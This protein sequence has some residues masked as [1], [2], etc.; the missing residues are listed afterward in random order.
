MIR[1]FRYPLMAT[2]AQKAVLVRW[3]ESCRTLFNAALE[4]RRDAWRRCGKSLTYFDQTRDLTVLRS[5]DPEW[6][7][8]PKE[9]GRSPLRNLDRAFQAFFRR[10][11]TGQAPGHPRFKGRGRYDSFSIGRAPVNG[12]RVLIPKLGPVRFRLYRELKGRVLD[13]TLRLWAGRWHVSFSCDLGDAPLKRPVASAIG[14]DVGLSAFATL[15]DGTRVGNPRF[16]KIAEGLLARRQRSLARKS[17]GSRSRERAKRLVQRAHAHVRNQ[18]L[19]FALK[20]ACELFARHDL[21]AYE[22]LDIKG[23]A[24]GT[25]AKSVHDAAWGV[26]ARALALKAE[27]AGAWAVP[28]DPHK[29]SAVCNACGAETPKALGDRI[30]RCP[31]GLVLDRDH[32]AALNILALG[33]SAVEVLGRSPN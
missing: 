29:T 21:V 15:S 18:R 11:K 24:G 33:R 13:V 17:R 25:L 6:A 8:I 7:G 19:D 12:D 27:C 9:V 23:L 30:H 5:A 32:N 31:C 16:F 4:Q 10:V 28:V 20:L 22:N 1:T 2:E 26:F 3:L 14:V